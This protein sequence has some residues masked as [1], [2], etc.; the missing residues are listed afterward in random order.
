MLIRLLTGLAAAAL[1]AGAQA[2]QKHEIKVATCAD[3]PRDAAFSGRRLRARRPADRVSRA[4]AVAARGAARVVLHESGERTSRAPTPRNSQAVQWLR[5]RPLPGRP[6][7]ASKTG[8]R[9]L[10]T[11]LARG[12]SSPRQAIFDNARAGAP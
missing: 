9:S 10:Q 5:V 4:R 2:Q 11:P 7:P 1:A 8:A 3:L 12:F 6:D